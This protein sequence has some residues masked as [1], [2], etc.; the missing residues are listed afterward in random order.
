MEMVH[1]FIEVLYFLGRV[2]KVDLVFKS[3]NAPFDETL[4]VS[5]LEKTPKH[6]HI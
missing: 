3:G 5:D 4:L 1:Q 6:N 2:G